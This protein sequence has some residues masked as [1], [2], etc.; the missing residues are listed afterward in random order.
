MQ[1]I[2]RLLMT[3]VM[4]LPLLFNVNLAQAEQVQL[5]DQPPSAAELGKALFGNAPRQ[6]TAAVQHASYHPPV[7]HHRKAAGHRKYHHKHK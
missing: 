3:A 5:Y 6:S 2:N 7:K 4:V 1:L